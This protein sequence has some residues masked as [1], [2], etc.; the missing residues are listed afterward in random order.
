MST[1]IENP[2]YFDHGRQLEQGFLECFERLKAMV[3]VGIIPD[4]I[5]PEVNV[6]RSGQTNIEIFYLNLNNRTK[7]SN[8]DRKVMENLGD[9][10]RD[11]Q[12]D[13]RDVRRAIQENCQLCLRTYSR[14]ENPVN[15]ASS[16]HDFLKIGQYSNNLNIC[17]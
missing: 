2:N 4:I 1:L 8:L 16:R 13:W 5:F 11:P 12:N 9:L 15:H 3:S 10:L 14:N 7:Y 6:F 17:S